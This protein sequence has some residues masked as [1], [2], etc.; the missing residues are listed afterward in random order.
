MKKALF[1]SM[2][3]ALAA[4]SSCGQPDDSL[5]R[6]P[7]SD[8]TQ[9]TFEVE[10]P[11]TRATV[12]GLTRYIV[13]AYE[14][15]DLEATPLREESATG[16]VTLILKKDTEYI[17]LFWADYGIAKT[18]EVESSGYYNTADLK[19]VSVTPAK[20]GSV[21]ER[22][23]YSAVSFNSRDFEENRFVV[24]KN[25]V[26]EV[27]L[28]ETGGLVTADNTVKITYPVSHIFN[29]NT[30]V[31]TEVAIPMTHTFTGI[32]K[33]SAE[34]TIATD[35]IFALQGEKAVVDIDLQF[36]AESVKKLTNV[37]FQCNY[38]TNIKGGYSNMYMSTFTISSEVDEW[39]D[40][41]NSFNNYTIGDPYPNAKN[42][43]GV[44]YA[45]SAGG[46]HGMVVS[47]EASRLPWSIENI[48]TGATHY[49]SG[50]VNVAIIKQIPDWGTKYPAIKYCDNKNNSGGET[51][52]YLPATQELKVLCAGYS[53]LKLVASGANPTKGEINDWGSNTM[54]DYDT[55]Y[56]AARTA[57]NETLTA[58]GGT[59]LDD[60][61]SYFC[62]T[63]CGEMDT[64]YAGLVAIQ[65]SFSAVVDS[66]NNAH[67]VRCIRAF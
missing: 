18:E 2:L 11:N 6:P 44:V 13:E 9:A 22:A 30:G 10:P 58:I 43:E 46:L 39:A 26:A 28:V 14:D 38:R 47:K 25:A 31:T 57:F 20:L 67:H 8:L 5:Q 27:N 32:T 4:L 1:F 33:V 15:R 37:P 61:F 35:Y 53:G 60:S 34:T 16:T 45:I 29:V 50:L 42:A 48:E 21:G 54:P 24:L 65:S 17:F 64:I 40:H 63:S 19:E 23:F 66:K 55:A 36:N 12:R 3:G 41:E 52:W 56:V 62:W 49:N 51:A 59:S 7:Q